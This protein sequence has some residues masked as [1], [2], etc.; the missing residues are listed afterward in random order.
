MELLIEKLVFGGQG[1]AKKDGRTYLVWNALPGETVQAKIVKKAQTVYEA[2]AEKILEASPD[3]I[4]AS[5]AHYLS[6]SPW[7]ILKFDAEN[8]FKQEIALETYR[9]VGGLKEMPTPPMISDGAKPFGYRNKIEYNFS[10]NDRALSLAFFERNTHKKYASGPCLLADDLLK[11]S[12]LHILEWLKKEGLPER[13]L[14]NLVIRS[15]DKD[16]AVAVLSLHEKLGVKNHPELNE[17][18]SGFQ[19]DHAEKLIHGAGE[20]EFVICIRQSSLKFGLRSFFQINSSL[21]EKTLDDMSSYL[22]PS[23][24]LVDFYSGVG[25]IGISLSGRYKNAVLVDSHEES[26]AYAKENI[27]LNGLGN[28]RAVL[29]PAENITRLI[30]PDTILIF[31]PPRAGLHVRVLD[32]V[33]AEKPAR[34]LYLS[35]DVATHARDIKTLSSCYKVKNLKLYNFFPR[36]PHIEAL[37]I[38][39]LMPQ[40]L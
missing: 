19:I 39:D 2:V 35:C 6:C 13:C 22:D 27:E 8:R 33:L 5:E 21:F 18:L 15:G 12:A 28:C 9:R 30:Q 24:T 26:I 4:P 36:T 20:K 32:K 29:S 25:S 10:M 34:I 17:T 11:K 37:A 14:K 3:R 38:L 16:S 7:Q 23:K 1:L 31:D 40:S